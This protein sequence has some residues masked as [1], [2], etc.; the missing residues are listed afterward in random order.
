MTRRKLFDKILAAFAAIGIAAEV[1]ADEPSY[2]IV[3][4]VQ[5]MDERG[6]KQTT[7]YREP[8][9]GDETVGNV[10]YRPSQRVGWPAS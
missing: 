4:F 5:T 7:Y 9:P 3:V 8:L 6:V 10:E 1:K 2:P